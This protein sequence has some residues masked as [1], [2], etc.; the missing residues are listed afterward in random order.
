MA[1]GR[2][3]QVRALRRR[4]RGPGRGAFPPLPQAA[5][6]AGPRRQHRPLAGFDSARGS[7]DRHRPGAHRA[8]APLGARARLPGD[9][10]RLAHDQPL[11][12]AVLAEARVP[13]GLSASL[14]AH[15]VKLP[16]LS[17]SSV[18]V[19]DAPDDA[20]VLRP[21]PPGE[22]LDDVRAAIRDALRFP[23]AGEP[24]AAL[25]R[26]GGRATIVVEPP[27]LPLPGAPN[28]PPQAALAAASAE[29]ER[30]GV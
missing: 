22:P 12:L 25:A 29:L 19:V 4:T 18:V 6:P 10:D 11:G 20:V 9:D 15:S 27:S 17:G 8:R 1:R 5:G 23:L 21:P 14:P 7:R 16:L 26:R 3:Q 13:A 2:W 24:L 30:G 28:D